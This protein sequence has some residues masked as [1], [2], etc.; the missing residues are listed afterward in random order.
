MLDVA[1]TTGTNT[2]AVTPPPG[3]QRQRWQ[4]NLA[5]QR[6]GGGDSRLSH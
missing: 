1:R 4:P 5:S 2:E 3:D 6:A